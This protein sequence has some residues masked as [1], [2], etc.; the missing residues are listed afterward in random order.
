MRILLF[1]AACLVPAAAFAQEVEELIV[2]ATRLPA[3]VD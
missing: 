3:F 1:A 2:T